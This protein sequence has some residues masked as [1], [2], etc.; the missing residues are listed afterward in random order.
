MDS[1]LESDDEIKDDADKDQAMKN[2]DDEDMSSDDSESE[3]EDEDEGPRG[4]DRLQIAAGIDIPFG[5]KI[6]IVSQL[7]KEAAM[8]E[9]K[10]KKDKTAEDLEMEA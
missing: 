2:D 6:P 3:E 10:N 1:D 4:A 5:L 9:A 7:A 8:R